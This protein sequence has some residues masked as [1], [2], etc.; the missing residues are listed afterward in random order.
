VQIVHLVALRRPGCLAF[1]WGC[2][3]A[4]LSLLH[5][6]SWQQK[7]LV[8]FCGRRQL[9]F[10]WSTHSKSL[11]PFPLHHDACV[12]RVL[13]ITTLRYSSVMIQV[14]HWTPLS[15]AIVILRS[16]CG[17]SWAGSG[18]KSGHLHV[19]SPLR[20]P[21]MPYAIVAI[22]CTMPMSPIMSSGKTSRVNYL[23]RGV[24]Q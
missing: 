18:S 5:L 11:W 14:L 12:V 6:V 23:D 24:R 15:S 7:P 17:L 8:L 19:V 16:M 1:C 10:I 9:A 3:W 2:G 22:T 20:R 13:S 4:L 21:R